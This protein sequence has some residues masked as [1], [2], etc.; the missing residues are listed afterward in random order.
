MKTFLG[1]LMLLILASSAAYSQDSTA[2]TL[3]PK[4]GFVPDAKTAVKIAEAVLD[5][6][7]GEKQIESERPFKATLQKGVWIVAG[8]LNCGAPSSECSGGTAVVK[9][10]KASGEILFMTHYK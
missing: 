9:I 3:K 10:S 5:P 2:P 8:T 6:V 1:M 4:D 7:Y